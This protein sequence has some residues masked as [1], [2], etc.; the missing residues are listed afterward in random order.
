[1]STSELKG[2]DLGTS[3]V[4]L[5]TMSGEKVNFMAQ[6]NAFVELPLVK[7]TEKMLA[8]EGILHTVDDKRLYVYGNRA[9]EFAKFLE[10]D[11]RRP[12]ARG[13]LNPAE[14]KNLEMIELLIKHLCG[15]ASDGDKVCFSIPSAP[16]DHKSDLVFHERS[17]QSIFEKLGYT[18]QSL[19][20]GLAIIYSELRDTNFTGIGMSFGGGMC[21]ICLSYLGLP[22][23]TLATTHSGDYIDQSAA[24][25]T[26]ETPTTAR[27]HK[28][29]SF[30]L[31]SNDGTALDHAIAIYYTDVIET[32]V[33]ALQG[34]MAETKKLPRFT[35]PIPLVCAGG[36]AMAKGF[37]PDLEAA[38][39]AADLPVKLSKTYLAKDVLN[40]TAKGALV[41]AMLNM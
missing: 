18:A 10:G 11:E 12:M 41:A 13:L 8:S 22:V 21:N 28:E 29:Q 19:N 27:L 3:R 9:D 35:A 17:V 26:G 20:E 14:P 15:E 32:A 7:M 40:T 33:A 16:A 1:M 4:V 25:V 5:A 38:L 31:D 36:T 39:R 30:R 24:S 34:A 37:M 6:R 2:L 23:F